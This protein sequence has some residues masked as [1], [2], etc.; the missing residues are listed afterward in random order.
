MNI[1]ST[2]NAFWSGSTVNF[3]RSGGGCNNTG[4][5][6]GVFDHEWGHGMDNNDALPNIANPGEGIPDVYASLRLNTSCIG[7]NFRATNCGGY[8]DPCL[9]CSGVRDIDWANRNSGIPHDI[10]SPFPTGIDALCGTGSGTP[11]GG[12]THCEGAA[13]AEAIWDLWNRDLTAAPFNMSFD[14]AREVATKL[15]YLGAGFAGN[16]FQC[17]ASE[18]NGCNADGGYLNFLAADDNDGDLTNGTPHMSAIFLAFNRH[19]IACGTPTVTDSGCPARPA[20]APTVSTTPLDRGMLVEWDDLG[21]SS[22]N[23]YRGEGVFACDFGKEFLGTTSTLSFVD[24]NLMNG[25]E[26]YY[27]VIPVGCGGECCFGPASSCTTGTPVAGANLAVLPGAMLTIDTGDGDDFLDNCEMATFWFDVDNTGTGSLTNVA[28]ASVRS[29]SHPGINSTITFDPVISASLADCDTGTGSFTFEGV[30]L[31]FNETVEFEIQVTADELAGRTKSGFASV[32]KVESDFQNFATRTFSV[33]ADNE[34]W[35]VVEGTF[36]RDDSDT[37]GDGSF[38]FRSSNGLDAQCD[39][40]RSPQLVL[41]TD[42]TLSLMNNYDIEPQSGGT[43]YD[44][45]NVGIVEEDGTRTLV[46]PDGGRL[47]NADSSGPGNY[48]GCN[49]PEEGWADTQA[50]W[51]ASSWSAG[52]LQSATFA[53]QPIQLEVIYSTD[54]A[55][56]QRGFWF[57]AVS[58]TN[59]DIQVPDTQADCIAGFIFGDGFESGDTSAWGRDNTITCP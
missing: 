56:A 16:W 1:N 55:L 46:T 4:E 54:A 59:V 25:M 50:T 58:V 18:F 41:N 20:T 47:Y 13:Y 12:S 32:S 19:G 36:D 3:Y 39:R 29:T 22:Y 10:N 57:D 8:G 51:G 52:A 24:D 48:T 35:L 28:I 45:A 14:T 37:A 43:W 49:E 23:V 27:I 6:A 7:R 53:G 26:Y 5:L 34:G 11:C 31:A 44:R 33:E 40:I 38:A 42:S 17:G 21:A 30:D 15:T 9:D 2:C